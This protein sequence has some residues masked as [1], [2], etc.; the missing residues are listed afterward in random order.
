MVFGKGETVYE[1]YWGVMPNR[2][3]MLFSTYN[4]YLEA[5][6]EL[7]ESEQE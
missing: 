4:E 7:T 6:R 1:G 5:L 3:P 2:E